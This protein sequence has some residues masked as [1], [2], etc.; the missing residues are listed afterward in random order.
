MTDNLLH[1][2]DFEGRLRQV[3]FCQGTPDRVPLVEAG[4]YT[5]AKERFL[6]RP[7]QGLR[8]EA[9]FWAAAGYDT[10]CVTSGM[11]EIVD[12]AIHHGESGQYEASSGEQPSITAAKQ[13][14]VEKLRVQ[15]LSSELQDGTRHWAP[16]HEGVIVTEQDFAAFPWPRPQD[17]NFTTFERAAGILPGGMKI[18][19]FSGAIFSTI[20]LMMG[21]ENFFVQLALG[22]PLVGKMFERIG[23]FQLGVVEILLEYDSV[24][25]IWINDDMGSS[26]STLVSPKHY[27]RYLFPWYERISEVVHRAGRP[28]LLH[29]DGCLY[30]ILEDLVRIGFNAIHPIEPK[31][32]DIQRV[33]QIVG[34]G[35]CLIGNVDLAFPLGTGEPQDVEQAVREL[36]RT[37][38]PQG[39]Y[40]VSSGNSIPEYVPYDNWLAL[41]DAVLKYGAYPI[42]A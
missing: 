14:A 40:C 21:M 2:P 38:A 1:G 39:G 19:P 30:P 33:R 13:Y 42:Q 17:I 25:A 23:A 7:I 24:G 29:S 16:S 32:M 4:I 36:I 28:L 34:P 6:G 12:A 8:D 11:R 26:T 15:R 20:S 10:F 9:E 18:I 22:Q 31:A 35:V 27:R 3:L 41:R 37:M 5:A